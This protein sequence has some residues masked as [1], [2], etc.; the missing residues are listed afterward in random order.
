MEINMITGEMK[1]DDFSVRL[2]VFG[3]SK[4]KQLSAF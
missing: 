1:R 3:S 4:C 2:V